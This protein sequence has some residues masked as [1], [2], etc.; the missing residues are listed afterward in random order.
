MK[1]QIHTK[2]F[3]LDYD[4]FINE[5]FLFLLKREADED[6]L[7]FYLSLFAI[8]YSKKI[9]FYNIFFSKESIS[10]NNIKVRLINKIIFRLNVLV[11][12]SHHNQKMFMQWKNNKKLVNKLNSLQF[13]IKSNLHNTKKPYD[14]LALKSLQ[15][16]E[17][18]TKFLPEKSLNLLLK[19]ARGA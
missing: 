16:N 8:G 11:D 14:D 7:K 5:T 6:S 1:I 2:L 13:E 9:I 18:Q 10:K 12:K 17:K 15:A 19:I 4:E 3:H